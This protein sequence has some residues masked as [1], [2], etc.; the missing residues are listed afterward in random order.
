MIPDSLYGAGAQSSPPAAPEPLDEA[1]VREALRQ[2]IDPEVGLDIVTLGLVYDVHVSDDVVLVRYTLTTPGC[3]LAGYIREAIVH[4]V[5][6]VLGGRR[7]DA[8]VIW[9][10][11]W[12]PDRIE[13]GAW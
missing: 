9:E 2:V 13:G 5:S 12:S 10:P 1:L 8:Q 7:L 3:P 4:E 11:R 6:A